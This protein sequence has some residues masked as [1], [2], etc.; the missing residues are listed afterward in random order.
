VV[1]NV[2]TGTVLSARSYSSNVI[3]NI[4]GLVKSMLI[5]SGAFP[6]AYVLSEDKVNS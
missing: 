1:F 4:K 6:M 3:K 5:S 2:E